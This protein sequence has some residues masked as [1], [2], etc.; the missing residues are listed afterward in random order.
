[1]TTRVDLPAPSGSGAA[2]VVVPSLIGGLVALSL[3]VYGACT[4]RPA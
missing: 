3:G 2:K 4:T 1:M